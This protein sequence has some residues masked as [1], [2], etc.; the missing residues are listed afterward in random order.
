[1]DFPAAWHSTVPVIAVTI[2]MITYYWSGFPFPP[3]FPPIS[4]VAFYRPTG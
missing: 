1:M 2:R 4:S 3:L